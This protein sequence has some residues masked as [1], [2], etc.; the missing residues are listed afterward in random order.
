MPLPP[1]PLDHGALY[2]AVATAAS[3]LVSY[4]PDPGDDEL[5]EERGVFGT[6]EREL[7]HIRSFIPPGRLA[8]D[9]GAGS[10]LYT[11]RIV[12]KAGR[13]IAFEPRSNA[14]RVTTQRMEPWSRSL[15][16]LNCAISESDGTATLRVPTKYIG[17]A[18]MD[19]RNSLESLDDRE[20][21]TLEVATL[22]VDR[23]RLHDVGFVKIDVE[24]HEGPVLASMVDTIR[25]CRPRFLIEATNITGGTTVAEIFDFFESMQYRGLR[26]V[27]GQFVPTDLEAY[28]ESRAVNA[29]FVPAESKQPLVLD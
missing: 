19:E 6:N 14:A 21:E 26:S 28:L 4:I 5:A 2:D 9:I 11:Y 23:M 10:G 27:D 3:T 25:R 16:V 13:C 22:V 1:A 18:T 7:T 17:W 8:L 12:S 20:C 29:A 24:G 15:T